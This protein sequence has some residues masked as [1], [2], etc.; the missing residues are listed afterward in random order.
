MRGAHKTCESSNNGKGEEGVSLEGGVTFR[1]RGATTV[2][3][4]DVGSTK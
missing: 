2:S 1:E 3:D 4:M